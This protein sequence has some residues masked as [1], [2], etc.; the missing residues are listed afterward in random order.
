M[1][2]DLADAEVAIQEAAER[3]CRREILPF[4]SQWEREGQ[5]PTDVIRRMG[6]QGFF[7]CPFPTRY[8]GTEAG[9][10][11]QSIII[12]EFTRAYLGI[13]YI[14]NVQAMLVPLAI[15]DFGTEEQRDRYLSKIL[16]GEYT[17]CF[18][19]TEPDAG[20][21]VAAI[22]TRAVR[23]GDYYVLNGSKMWATFGDVADVT[24]LFAKTVPD[25]GHRGISAFLIDKDIPGVNRVVIPSNVGS[26][27][28]HSAEI[29][30]ED[31]RI[32]ATQLLGERDRGF[33]VAM[34]LLEY[35]RITVGSRCLGIA[36]RCLDVALRYANER[37]AFGQPIGRYQMLQD[38][39]ARSV[40]ETE[41][42]R[43]LVRRATFLADQ[44]RPFTREASIAKY[45]AAE[46]AVNAA[47]MALDVHGGMAFSEEFGINNYLLAANVMR[48]GE[49]H[50]NIQKR[51]IAEDAL[52]YKVANRHAPLPPRY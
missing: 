47:T 33:V 45:L 28:V 39:I 36:Q 46:T 31:A 15:H 4:C 40:A 27:C 1:N 22:C 7:G 49:G 16:A 29:H 24:V 8:G 13:G 32:P 17:G 25:G 35:G 41:A 51:L 38:T 2:F 42:A 21:D 10:L 26:R 9:F 14:F 34:R 3:F 12:E 6:Q 37:Q 48:T 19:L 43:L 44:H 5:Y 11:A 20:S 30:L 52:G 23:N 18:S 50:A